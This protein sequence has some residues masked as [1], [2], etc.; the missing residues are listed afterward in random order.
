MSRQQ[1][2]YSNLK[3]VEQ[4]LNC[5]QILHEYRDSSWNIYS[6]C[7]ARNVPSS[8]REMVTDVLRWSHRLNLCEK[9]RKARNSEHS[10]HSAASGRHYSQQLQS[11]RSPNCVFG[12]LKKHLGGRHFSNY[13][14]THTAVL[15]LLRDWE[16]IFYRQ[17]IE[18]LMERSNKCMQRLGDYVE[19]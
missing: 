15:S 18:W 4:Y 12:R 6:I 3:Y 9:V 16:A 17:G 5:G 1:E 19:K 11:E 10:R 8:Y 7:I 2:T 13:D 14:Q